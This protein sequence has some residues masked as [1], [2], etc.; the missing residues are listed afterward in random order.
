MNKEFFSGNRQRFYERIPNGSA[1]VFFS[2]EEVCKTND[3]AYPFFADRNFLYLTGIEQ[4]ESVYLAIK[5]DDGRIKEVLY[6]LPSDAYLERWTGKR[7]TKEEAS[8]LSGIEEV[9]RID[10][11]EK[12]FHRIVRDGAMDRIYIDIFKVNKEDRDRPAHRFLRDL[13]TNY[14]SLKIENGNRLVRSLRLIKQPCEIEALREAERI[15]GEGIVAM[16]K[17]SKPGMWEYQYKAVF[18]SVLG[19][20]G[21][22]MHGFPP[23]ISAGDNNFCIHYYSYKGQAKDGDMI[24]N[25]VGV[26]YNYMINDVSR[27]WPCNGKFTERQ[28]ILY[29]C[30]LKTSDYLFSILKPGNKMVDVDK[31]V[32]EYNAKLLVEAGVISDVSEV[33][34]VMWHGGAH[35]IG[36]DVHDVVENPEYI[37]ENMVFC[38]DIGIYVED[39]GIGFRLEDNCLITKDGCENLSKDI[40]RTI[41]EIEAVMAK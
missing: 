17:A 16:M 35:H 31:T 30:A 23:I 41:E 11:F 6:I 32:K 21:P 2:G 19:N 38:V 29:E 39:W 4:K 10:I 40:P 33:S 13:Q 25:D 9:R 20:Y 15:T 1:V 3:E 24:L 36:F 8:E 27:G 22:E 26:M 28:K 18:D 34:K 14:P 37:E 7:L 5:Y 12:D